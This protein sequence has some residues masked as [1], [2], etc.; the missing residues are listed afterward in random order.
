M[1]EKKSSKHKE[2]LDA[3]LKL[4]AK[5]DVAS[6]PDDI[7]KGSF[8]SS[9]VWSK[10]G[11][12]VFVI[13]VIMIAIIS[14]FALELPGIPI[15]R[16]SLGILVLSFLILVFCFIA[17]LLRWRDFTEWGALGAIIAYL[18]IVLI[19]VP[20]ILFIFTPIH[21][22]LTFIIITIGVIIMII[23][24][25]SH[26][27]ELDRKISTQF[28]IFIEWV[29][30]GGI[31]QSLSAFKILIG[32]TL[33]GIG[34]YIVQ[35]FFN[36]PRRFGRFLRLL[37]RSL[38]SLS[39]GIWYNVHWI[40]LIGLIFLLLILEHSFFVNFE[41]LIIGGFFFS[42]GVIY[43]RYDR[44]SNIVNRTGNFVL[45]RVVSVYSMLTGTK[46]KATEAVY[47]TRC[48]R[49]VERR[50]F[51][52]LMEVKGTENPPCPFCGYTHWITIYQKPVFKEAVFEVT[53]AIIKDTRIKDEAEEIVTKDVEETI[54][55]P[56]DEKEPEGYV[57]VQKDQEI[58]FEPSQEVETDELPIFILRKN[59]IE[60]GQ[61]LAPVNKEFREWHNWFLKQTDLFSTGKTYEKTYRKIIQRYLDFLQSKGIED[62]ELNGYTGIETT[63]DQDFSEEEIIQEEEI[64]I[65]QELPVSETMVL[66][67]PQ[68]TQG[69]FKPIKYPKSPWETSRIVEPSR[70]TKE[71]WNSFNYYV[72]ITFSVYF[73]YGLL[74]PL[75][76]PILDQFIGFRFFVFNLGYSTFLFHQFSS[77]IIYQMVISSIISTII[78]SIAFFVILRPHF[79]G[80]GISGYWTTVQN[81]LPKTKSGK[82]NLLPFLYIFVILFFIFSFILILVFIYLVPL[83]FL[84]FLPFR[85]E[86]IQKEA[87][88]AQ[89]SVLVV[90]SSKE[91]KF[92]ENRCLSCEAVIKTEN[93]SCPFCG[94]KIF[95]ETT[96]DK[97]EILIEEEIQDDLEIQVTP[98]ISESIKCHKCGQFQ[99]ITWTYCPD[100]GA[101]LQGQSQRELDIVNELKTLYDSSLTG[102]IFFLLQQ[103]EK[104]PNL[105]STTFEVV[106]NFRNHQ[107]YEIKML[108]NSIL[109]EI[110]GAQNRKSIG[111]KN[112]YKATR[113]A[114]R[115]I[116]ARTDKITKDK[117]D[118]V[119]PKPPQEAVITEEVI[120]N[121]DLRKM[122]NLGLKLSTL[123][124]TI[125]KWHEWFLQQTKKY[126][127]SQITNFSYR[128]MLK[129]YEKF[130]SESGTAALLLTFEN[131][132][133]LDEMLALIHNIII[134]L[135]E[136]Q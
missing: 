99:K 64:S 16:S 45:K 74:I 93:R 40:G 87:Q 5:I 44:M 17:D 26:A 94:A 24:F 31:Q 109:P 36:L 22:L 70:V 79:Y 78:C 104:M 50:E 59:L 122:A 83:I 75:I 115:A 80:T 132:Q 18:G 3:D 56:T 15:E 102:R 121:E 19:F 100:C 46:L 25:A 34:K 101:D 62:L 98:E 35:G 73:F 72:L 30:A 91:E 27:T 4:D 11:L 134:D 116:K 90:K 92:S 55:S 41:L 21:N 7:D 85:G 76:L 33:G 71:Y 103:L 23:G 112:V 49:G 43:P 52:S 12:G 123:D 77:N 128:S 118:Q 6:I 58:Q 135:Q 130:L 32:T 38:K 57:D 105:S 88:I 8:I 20:I 84:Y 96:M 120:K 47:C 2:K 28:F 133:V 65:T 66:E 67:E 82:A 42:L 39:K 129:N 126:Q 51:M 29:K 48:L 114:T 124:D 108:V 54:E 81:K 127:K 9:S 53:E 1:D 13:A 61:R 97:P 63:T 106:R 89:K 131:L 86:A 110:K 60:L 95:S 136:K 113:S 69:D 14:I 111:L 125:K 117:P 37:G 10:Y 68:E 107:N 119:I